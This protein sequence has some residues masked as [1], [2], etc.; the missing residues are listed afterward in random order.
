MK[1]L[2][3]LVLCLSM[4]F[5]AIL[6]VFAA[7][8]TE[9]YIM[10]LTDNNTA[11][12]IGNPAT[13]VYLMDYLDNQTGL[14]NFTGKTA[15][16]L[17][18][19]Y[20]WAQG[21]MY[22]T[23]YGY[24]A[25]W[26]NV[27]YQAP[28]TIA[29]DGYYSFAFLGDGGNGTN[30]VS[31]IPV[32][33]DDGPTYK[34]E[35]TNYAGYGRSYYGMEHV[36]LEAGQHVFH[37]K[38]NT[39]SNNT[40]YY[41]GFKY[42]KEGYLQE[43]FTLPS[44][45]NNAEFVAAADRVAVD[46]PAI[47]TY[48]I[49]Q[50]TQW[51]IFDGTVYLE[52]SSTR[53]AFKF[54]AP[55]SGHYEIAFRMIGDGDTERMF[56]RITVD[57][58][59][60]VYSLLPSGDGIFPEYAYYT[61]ISMDLLEGEHTLYIT[62]NSHTAYFQGFYVA[63][64]E[65]KPNME[66]DF[67][68]NALAT[69]PVMSE[70]FANA[71]TVTEYKF[72]EDDVVAANI[73]NGLVKVV[74][75]NTGCDFGVERYADYNRYDAVTMFPWSKKAYT[76]EFTVPQD[77]W[78]EFR[79]DFISDNNTRGAYLQIDGGDIY[80]AALAEPWP[81]PVSVYG[82]KAKL[83]A[84]SHTF[85]LYSD[86]GGSCAYSQGFAF[87]K[88]EDT[89]GTS[90]MFIGANTIAFYDHHETSGNVMTPDGGN[91]YN[92]YIWNP[93]DYKGSMPGRYGVMSTGTYEYKI[94]FTPVA[95]GLYDLGAFLVH[96]HYAT[97]RAAAYNVTLRD[98][99]GIVD[100]FMLK[101]I[102]SSYGSKL[103]YKFA[104]DVELRAGVTYTIGFARE[105]VSDSTLVDFYYKQTGNIGSETLPEGFED[106]DIVTLR[107][108]EAANLPNGSTTYWPWNASDYTPD[109]DKD[110]VLLSGDSF[111]YNIT[112]TPDESGVYSLAAYLVNSGRNN[113]VGSRHIRL[114]DANGEIATYT[115]YDRAP[116][117][118]GSK[119]YYEFAQGVELKAGVTYTVGFFTHEISETTIVDFLYDRTGDS[120]E[121]PTSGNCGEN[122]IWVLGSDGVLHVYGNG[123]MYD[124]ANSADTPW[125]P[126]RDSIMAVSISSGVT[127]VGAHAFEA[128]PALTSV[129]IADT[130]ASIGAYAFA[131]NNLIS[132][133]SLPG[134]AQIGEGAFANCAVLTSV[135]LSEGVSIISGSAFAYCPAL[136]TVS[137]PASLST[138][139]AEAFRGCS[140]LAGVTIPA[141]VTSIGNGAFAECAAL[142]SIH[143]PASVTSIGSGAFASCQS[144]TAIT[145]DSSNSVYTSDSNGVL[146]NKATSVL[147]QYPAGKTAASY[148][149]RASVT[150]IADGA[151]AGCISLSAVDLAQ[152]TTIGANAFSGCVNLAAAALPASVVTVG[153]GA[154]ES[155]ALTAVEI[156]ASVKYVGSRAFGGCKSLFAV[157]VSS[158]TVYLAADAFPGA[159]ANL[160]ISANA[161]S[162]AAAHAAQN[163][164][165]F[166]QL[167]A[168]STVASGV[169]GGNI[170]WSVDSNGQLVI[171]GSGAMADPLV[172]SALPWY[173]YK[174]SVKTVVIQSG[175]TSIGEYAFYEFTS[176]TSVSI[177]TT[178]ASIGAYAF[179]R[180]SA[181]TSVQIPAGVTTI[182][183]YA[184]AYANKLMSVTIPATVTSIGYR[185]FA[186][187]RTLRS[188]SVDAANTAYTS[189][190]SGA[191]FNKGMTTLILYPI[192]LMNTTFTIPNT[193][194][195]IAPYAFALSSKLTTITIP[196]SVQTIGEHAFDGCTALTSAVV[197]AGVTNLSVYAFANCKKLADVTI[198][199]GVAT[200]GAFAFANCSSLTNVTLP[201]SVTELGA[202]AFQNCAALTTVTMP[203]ELETICVAAFEG[204]TN[205]SNASIPSSVTTL[206]GRA[207]DSCESL[208]SASI[209][210]GMTA[211]SDY[212]FNGC[213]SL[214]SV[215]V[216]DSVTKI[217]AG[218][219]YDCIALTTAP[220]P[221]ATE[222]IESFAFYNCNAIKTVALPATLTAIR[223]MAFAS[224]NALT[225]FS[226]DAENPNYSNDTNG[227]L[228]NK[229]QT[230]LL[231]YPLNRVA[232]V[233]SIPSTV[234]SIGPAA[235]MSST[236]L[237]SV[238]VPNT[239]STIS[240]YAFANCTKLAVLTIPN[241]VAT[242]AYGAYA[243]CSALSSIKFGTGV[244]TIQPYAFA[245]CAKI[246]KLDL[247]TKLSRIDC[248]AF[249]GCTKL[250]S[251]T[252]NN[253]TVSLG[254][255]AFPM[256]GTSLTVNAPAGSTAEKYA[257]NYGHTFVATTTSSDM[258]GFY[259]TCGDTAFWELSK[260]GVLT[261]TGTGA[262]TDYAYGET[263]W[264]NYRES[265]KRV[266]IAEGI[267]AIGYYA[268][269]N[270][271]ALADVSIPTTLTAIGD[272]AF[273]NTAITEIDLA[274]TVTSIG[275]GAFAI[276]PYFV[277][278]TV[279][280]AS[281]AI[282]ADAFSCAASDFTVYGYRESTAKTYAA[283]NGHAFVALDGEAPH[284]CDFTYA[285]EIDAE[286]PH[287]VYGI[288]ECGEKQLQAESSDKADCLVCHPF[289]MSGA[290][291]TLGN[292]L[293]LSFFFP[294]AKIPA[295][296]AC[297]VV[298]T[299]EYAD[300]RA[301]V[302]RTFTP[303]TWQKLGS[304]L[305]YVS[306]NGIAAKE[307][308]DK[309]TVQVFN[310]QGQPISAVWVDS[311]QDY[312][313][314]KFNDFKPEEKTWAV[315]CLNYGAASQVDFNYATDK[316][317]NANLTEEQLALGTQS[318]TMVDQSDMGTVGVGA[319]LKLESSIELVVFFKGITDKTGMY[320][321]ISFTNYNG[322]LK[323][324]T[325]AA[326]EFMALGSFTGVSVKTMVEADVSQLITI[327]MYN[328]DG[329]VYGAIK[330]SVESYASR[331]SAESP[332]FE[333]V[334][335]F[336][337]AAREMFT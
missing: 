315:D 144:L 15:S 124:Y 163:G 254:E 96:N 73:A 252:V 267:T 335:K 69:T 158:D 5:S 50:G 58:T 31:Y 137:L 264:H 26:A 46:N 128:C 140:S 33:I 291:L 276:N 233:Y 116:G 329:S 256:A 71:A 141:A 285:T 251:V 239:V 210:A 22:L 97:N 66:F 253:S 1:K 282:G 225:A 59:S 47:T 55:V 12:T 295:N 192:G 114:S 231:Q 11:F 93:S 77:G 219:F 164:Y 108:Q 39:G 98:S 279:N 206:G 186:E 209:P 300:G 235:F 238:S 294:V 310:S 223:S 106:A 56:P 89:A 91:T 88:L 188:I 125:Y 234:S 84:G 222:L 53:Y 207:F 261:V 331:K 133:I 278:I 110:G 255:G 157:T 293:S 18:A 246:E 323:T 249:Y 81:N 78:Y 240:M 273:V 181:L 212:L 162:T 136:T 260:D 29:E 203:Q 221:A 127:Y 309:M 321:E 138:I 83:T 226:V 326:E 54:N 119:L 306:F 44:Q 272:H 287:A 336:G 92:Y 13:T 35:M 57:G 312:L 250:T 126:V 112:F 148:T 232:A 307:M 76:V 60:F 266:V 280:G 113:S 297:Y 263:P 334:V 95:S 318:V 169:Y 290:S 34:V 16:N 67:T 269:Y 320:A 149:V 104:E 271:T 160:A 139:G 8:E 316:L 324:S 333:K 40:Q 184:F 49:N 224:C 20:S 154:F 317:V 75:D 237:M 174:D 151:F 213:T 52:N 247:P 202:A 304:T 248:N 171:S 72:Y 100:A 332:L 14:T 305:Y 179:A 86:F 118:L 117:V 242:I 79:Y 142:T 277:K 245:N 178:V 187:C 299:K 61:G 2:L 41:Y 268:F 102:P 90:N 99:S 129:T 159:F 24:D 211:V 21:G 176:L 107:D 120:I 229:K 265:I 145:V 183:T 10:S 45:F 288:C 298:V 64:T 143:L 111:I 175:V 197:P 70:A 36:W 9:D 152:V 283:N 37:V 146:Y 48:T 189:S 134:V 62:P 153:E 303:D 168:T 322:A 132:A 101:E 173:P 30:A 74:D 28:F 258:D 87:V 284:V 217:G 85:K 292:E 208:T 17:K 314:R 216:P 281:T 42:V 123:A 302:T 115:L 27:S 200:I 205:L 220:I 330:D 270:C 63:C 172:I 105:G 121:E 130:V 196:A 165:A 274:D 325:V 308:G 23:F 3:A 228:M 193:V 289:S 25:L 156:P 103:Y 161:G 227:I 51:P 262:M 259:G 185:A 109:L 135:G 122:L 65:E 68:K 38:R 190:N 199:A 244:R 241:S 4:V 201:V 218:A 167:S 43:E 19:G 7:D 155:C 230:T 337:I 80:Y 204:C 214:T 82:M 236:R 94:T 182:G 198:N 296:D 150:A 131:N 177:P 275:A 286:H 32:S 194:T 191:L 313:T 166:T 170:V 319:S 311:I 6:P 243:N 147:V 180:C 328:A 327:T 195:E 257:V 301:D 215:T